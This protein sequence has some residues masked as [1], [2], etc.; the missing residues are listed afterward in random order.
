MNTTDPLAAEAESFGVPY[1]PRV[2]AELFDPALIAS[3]PVTWAREQAVLP[4][5]LPDGRAVLLMPGTAALGLVQQASLAAGAALEPAF[6][7]RAEILRAVEE[8][9]FAG[10]SRGA[11]QDAEPPQTDDPDSSLVT[12]HSSL[13]AASAGADAAGRDLLVDSAE[14]VARFLNDTLLDAVRR[15]ASDV[16][17]D[18]APDGGARVR[19]RLSGRLYDQAPPPRGLAAQ[20]V[21]R[22]KVLAGMDI[23]EHRLPQDGMTQVRAGGGRAVDIRVSTIPVA[24]GERVVMR[25]LNRDDS[26]LPLAELGMP[27]D[28]R[29][30]FSALLAAPNGIVVVSGPTGSGKTTTLYSALGTLDATRRNVMTIEDPVEYRLPGIAQIQVAPKIGLTFASGLRHVLRQ[31]PDVV[32]VGETRDAETAEIAVRASLTGHLVF[33]TLHTNDAPSAVMRLV[34]M[35]VEPYLL[36]SCLRGVLA[37]RLVRRACPRCAR[38]LPFG[39][40]S[41]LPSEEV[42]ARAAGAEGVLRAVG[43]DRCLEGYVGR[44]GVFEL[45]PCGG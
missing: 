10:K 34:D 39:D 35:G 21:S 30:G 31:D 11:G 41:V 36:A 25:L 14:P 7:P 6:A 28:V 12:R 42:V 5:R 3:V 44:V 43:C 45:L 9:W 40:P 29:A 16:H 27:D 24:D 22:V 13:P 26:L 18:P 19:F 4:A 17:F 15:G 23:A 2:G 20:L 37:Q 8:A 1:V 32:L 38:M 33:T